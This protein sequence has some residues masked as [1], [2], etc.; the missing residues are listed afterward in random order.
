MTMKVNATTH[1][2]IAALMLLAISQTGCVQTQ[3]THLTAQPQPPV[4]KEE[5]RVYRTPEHVGCAYDEVAII[6]AQGDVAFTNEHRMIKA[7]KERAGK[8]GANGV[9]LG[10]IEE[11]GV[12]ALAAALIG[13]LPDR[14]GELLAIFVHSPCRPLT[15]S[16][17]SARTGSE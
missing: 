12:G 5:V 17:P 10:P 6:H 9:V 7:A 1:V 11:P 15:T 13:F 2:A 3:A 16:E 8:V 14:R 4:P